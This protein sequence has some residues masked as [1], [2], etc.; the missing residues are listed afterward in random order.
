[1]REICLHGEKMVIVPKALRKR[2]SNM[3]DGVFITPEGEKCGEYHWKT[4]AVQWLPEIFTEHFRKCLPEQ[5]QP[6]TTCMNF[7]GCAGNPT[8]KEM[9]NL[10]FIKFS[11]MAESGEIGEVMNRLKFQ[12]FVWV[13]T[14]LSCEILITRHSEA[15]GMKPD[16][17]RRHF[18]RFVRTG[19]DEYGQEY[20]HCEPVELTGY[21]DEDDENFRVMMK[22]EEDAVRFN[23]DGEDL[24]LTPRGVLALEGAETEAL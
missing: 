7:G 16:Y 18:S 22:G 14:R 12:D 17:I 23:L 24:C 19:I 20:G 13:K 10:F 15:T 3:G 2:F 11:S 6:Q 8:L 4:G 9:R 5:Q 21:C 1:M